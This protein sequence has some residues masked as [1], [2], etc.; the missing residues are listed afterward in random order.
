[1]KP[2]D[3]GDVSEARVLA[4]F[5]AAGETALLPWGDNRRYDIALDRDG[6]L[7]R[8]QVKTARMVDGVLVADLRSHN[9]GVYDKLYTEDEVDVF[10][11]YSP[12]LERLFWV[13][14]AEAPAVEV[15]LRVAPTQNGQ[16]AGVRWADDYEYRGVSAPLAGL[17]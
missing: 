8:V 10:A 1:M 17:S 14:F 13:P 3:R 7:V 6:E 16:S 12:D 5:V 15:S 2:K 9:S 11:L 4:R